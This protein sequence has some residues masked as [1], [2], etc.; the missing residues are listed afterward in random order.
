MVREKDPK[1]VPYFYPGKG[2]MLSG[3]VIPEESA[4]ALCR[5]HDIPYCPPE[6]CPFRSIHLTAAS[7]VG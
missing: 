6:R 1:D 4:E 2:W 3:E 5:E 7:L